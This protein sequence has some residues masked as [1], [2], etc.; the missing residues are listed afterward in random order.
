MLDLHPVFD[1]SARGGRHSILEQG[2]SMVGGLDYE[3]YVSVSARRPPARA[4]HD[5]CGVFFR[6]RQKPRHA[7]ARIDSGA[8]A[9][10][11]SVIY[12]SRPSLT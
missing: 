7:A 8:A 12:S 2:T 6:E 1:R 5:L 4:D 3:T 11:V 9:E 10:S